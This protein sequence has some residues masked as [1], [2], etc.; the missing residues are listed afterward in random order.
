MTTEPGSPENVAAST[1]LAATLGLGGVATAP[2]REAGLGIFGG[3]MSKE[4]V[5]LAE[6]MEDAGIAENK[7][8]QV[9]GLE[10][11]AEGLWKKNIPGKK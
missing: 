2:A 3:R 6:L 5:G 4:A 7:I 8:K 10:R 9:T 1:N 11:G